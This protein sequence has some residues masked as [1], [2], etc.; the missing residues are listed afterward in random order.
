ML[1]G[2][3]VPYTCEHIKRFRRGTL[4][5]TLEVHGFH[6]GGMECADFHEGVIA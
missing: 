5:P 6:Y 2:H 4:N 1:V 3:F